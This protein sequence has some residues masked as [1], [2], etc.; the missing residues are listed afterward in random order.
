MSLFQLHSD[1]SLWQYTGPPVTGW[2]LLDNNPATTSIVAR[3][4][5]LYQ[6]HGDGSIWKY[7]GPLTGWA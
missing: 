6:M 3:G 4:G 1:G 5:T 2:Q 7:T